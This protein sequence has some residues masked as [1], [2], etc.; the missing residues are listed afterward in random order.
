MTQFIHQ[1][2]RIHVDAVIHPTAV[3]GAHS[4]I[5]AGS[6][7]EPYAVV[8][9]HTHLG[10]NNR[11]CSFAVVGGSA[12]DRSTATNAPYR[13]VVGDGNVFREGV[14][15][16][17]GTAKG[18][19]MT[20]IGDECL[21]MAQAHVGHDCRLGNRITLSNQ[22]SL[23]GHVEV[24]DNVTCGGHSAVHQFVRLGTLSFLAANSMVSQDVPPFCMAAGDRARLLGLNSTGLERSGYSK[25]ERAEIG[26]V[27]RV[28][29]RRKQKLDLETQN[30]L[31]DSPLESVRSFM[32][33]VLNSQ[34]G[35]ARSKT[36]GPNDD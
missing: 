28:I 6:V 18:G 29:C 21:I 22:V 32:G 34:R 4:E 27:F 3:I 11:V 30:S 1:D 25:E 5:G 7:I 9:P 31:L 17:R 20:T 16:S 23:A 14:T 10:Q 24:A 19:G 13:L 12:Q 26:R 33:F 35:I 2:A 36:L 15:I 8:G